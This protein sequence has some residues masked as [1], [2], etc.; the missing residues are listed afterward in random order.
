MD[1][2][3][4]YKNDVP[5]ASFFLDLPD[6]VQ[7][8]KDECLFRLESASNDILCVLVGILVGFFNGKILLEQELFVIGQ[9]DHNGYI[10]DVLQPS[11][12]MS[13]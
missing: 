6:K 11:I 3:I 4:M 13:L 5:F 2:Y 7:I 10:K 12:S 9:L 1:H 8:G